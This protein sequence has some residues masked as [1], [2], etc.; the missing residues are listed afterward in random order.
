VEVGGLVEVG[1]RGASLNIL[2]S[3]LSPVQHMQSR[4]A[5]AALEESVPVSSEIAAEPAASGRW[6]HKVEEAGAQMDGALL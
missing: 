4:L 3:S 6:L 2:L 5:R 1:G